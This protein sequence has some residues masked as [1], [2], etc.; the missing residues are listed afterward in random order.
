MPALADGTLATA[1]A[2]PWSGG[3]VTLNPDAAGRITGNVF[4]WPQAAEGMQYRDIGNTSGTPLSQGFA[5]GTAGS[6][7]VS[8]QDHTGLGVLPGY[9]TAPYRVTLTGAGGAIVYSADFDSWHASGA[10]QARSATLT[11]GVGSYT[12]TFASQ[13]LPNHTDTLIDAVSVLGPAP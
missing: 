1:V 12:L 9:Q 7:T 6:V 10:W 8:W 13:N 3:V 2:T 11:L 5:I 4:V